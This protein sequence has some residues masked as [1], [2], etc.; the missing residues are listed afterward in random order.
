MLEKPEGPNKNGQSKD[1]GNIEHKTENEDKD[2][3]FNGRVGGGHMDI[4]HYSK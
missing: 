4:F 3:S 1:V 2:T